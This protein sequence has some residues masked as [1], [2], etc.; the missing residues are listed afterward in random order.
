[1]NIFEEFKRLEELARTPGEWASIE[2][3]FANTHSRDGFAI[4]AL[5]WKWK[6]GYGR[7]GHLQPKHDL[8]CE[9]SGS[10]SC[11]EFELAE[12]RLF[13]GRIAQ[14]KDFNFGLVLVAG[15]R[16]MLKLIDPKIIELGIGLPVG[17]LYLQYD[18]CKRGHT[19]IGNM[20]HE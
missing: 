14:L 1:M 12:R 17:L 20:Q 10:L 6:R 7:F 19:F 18:S 8:L 9:L 5:T 3:S 11:E 13:V 15:T 16:G 4:E 2:E